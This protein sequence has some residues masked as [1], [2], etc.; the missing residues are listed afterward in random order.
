MN[1]LKTDIRVLLSSLN[2]FFK[3]IPEK[4]KVT[5]SQTSISAMLQKY[6]DDTPQN[7]E[8]LL[9]ELRYKYNFYKL[10]YPSIIDSKSE[11]QPEMNQNKAETN[12]EVK[13][14]HNLYWNNMVD[15]ES[16][17][18]VESETEK[19]TLNDDI[20]TAKSGIIFSLG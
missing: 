12:I 18:G 3:K 16:K 9:I 10:A 1:K 7:L 4:H 2:E 20:S 6:K 15:E 17:S 8:K 11:K 5:K 13:F 14:D 19:K